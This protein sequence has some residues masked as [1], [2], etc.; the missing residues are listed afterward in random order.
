MKFYLSFGKPLDPEG[1]RGVS[2]YNVPQQLVDVSGL[3]AGN[4]RDTSRL[5]AGKVTLYG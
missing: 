5:S 4:T 1:L 2:R 3:H